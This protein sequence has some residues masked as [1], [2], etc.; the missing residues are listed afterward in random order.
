MVRFDGR[1]VLVPA[2]HA[3]EPGH[4]DADQWETSSGG[5]SGP[6][7]Q[8]HHARVRA[9]GHQGRPVPLGQGHQHVPEDLGDPSLVVVPHPGRATDEDHDRT[10]PAESVPP[11][12]PWQVLRAIHARAPLVGGLVAHPAPAS[13]GTGARGRRNRP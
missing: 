8:P 13:L 4:R 9:A 11:Q 7:D 1:P 3:H 12:K 5:R 2:G 6:A 10:V